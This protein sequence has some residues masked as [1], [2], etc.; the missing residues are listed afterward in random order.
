[1]AATYDGVVIGAGVMGASS[2]LQLACGGMKRVLVVEKGLGAGSGSTGRST[3]VVRQTY[4]NREVS[5]M[6]KE[7]LGLFQNWRDFVELPEPRANFIGCGVLFLFG[8]GEPSVA[9]IVKLHEELGIHSSVMSAEE[10]RRAFPD[11][12]F[13]AAS[14]ETVGTADERPHEAV[15]LLEHEGGFAD[16]VGTAEDML[17]AAVAQGAEVRFRIRVL[18]IRQ[19]GGRVLG[20]TLERDG[21]RE[22]VDCPV[23]INCAGPWGPALN[24]AAGVPL[25]HDLVPTRIQAVTKGFR[26]QPK[27]PLPVICDLVTGFYGRL[28]AG[29]GSL[30]LGSLREEDEM[31]TVADPDHY[32]EVADAPFREKTMSLLQHRVPTFAT[33]GQVGSYAGLYTVNRTDSHPIIDA[34]PLE[35]FFYCNGW[36]GHGFKLSPV[37]G[38]LVAR[39]VLGSSGRS[40][41]QVPTDFFRQ[42]RKPLT[43]NWGGV[44]A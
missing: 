39:Q 2:A 1:M 34:A 40:D 15:A 14:P 44:I 38:M 27:G 6:A 9:H 10:K 26:E 21:Q 29:G 20:V 35:G 36:S 31:E 22:E 7:A 11:L 19:A 33:R 12:D 42:D 3:A 4:S 28:E 24:E 30:I 25:A 16:P 43:T 5:L 23:V 32:N 41:T 17:E 18:D 13:T 37:A 8:E